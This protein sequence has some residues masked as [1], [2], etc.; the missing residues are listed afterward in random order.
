MSSRDKTI[1]LDVDGVCAD[2]I[3]AVLD[4]V[5]NPFPRDAIKRWNFF[6]MLDPDVKRVLFSRMRDPLWWAQLDPVPGAMAGVRRLRGAGYHIVFATVPWRECSSWAN[7]RLEWLY[8]YFSDIPYNA[9]LGE[10]K[11]LLRCRAIIDD[12]AETIDRCI[13]AGNADT[14]Y[15]YPASYNVEC[16]AKR[17]DWATLGGL[18]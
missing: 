12:K 17:F 9:M 4:T 16:E 3:G 11:D 5:G 10:R 2:F 14:C 1:I 7:A 8:H 13:A 15:I 18:I 6:D